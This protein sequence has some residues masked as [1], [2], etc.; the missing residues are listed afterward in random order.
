MPIKLNIALSSGG[1]FKPVSSRTLAETRITIGR[2]DDCTLTL[3]D[4]H[5]HVSRVHAELEEVDGVYMMKVVS[6]VNPVLVNGKRYMFGNRVALAEGD[7]L[8]IG[9]YRLEVAVLERPAKPPVTPDE[10]LTYVA[11][12]LKKPAAPPAPPQV[13]PEE[14]AT[15][16]RRPNAPPV[17]PPAKPPLPEQALDAEEATFVPP[18]KAAPELPK[19][20]PAALSRFAPPGGEEDDGE[21][22]LVRRPAPPA[23]PVVPPTPAAPPD[24]PL[25]AALSRFAP[26]GGE[27]D[28]GEAT[29]MR[30]P[31]TPPAP[32][33]KP[34]PPAMTAEDAEEAT[35]VPQPKAPT[36]VAQATP[37]ASAADEEEATYVPSPSARPPL[38]D[39]ATP[40]ART[41]PPEALDL[42]FDLSEEETFVRPTETAAP[43]PAAAPSA[44]A[45]LSEEATFVRPS[46]PL[47][48]RKPSA[49]FAAAAQEE[50]DSG[51]MTLM[52]RPGSPLPVASPPPSAPAPAAVA[53]A[54][55]TSPASG[56]DALLQA[57]LQGAGLSHLQ[58]PDPERFMRDSGTMVRAAIEGVMMLLIARAEARRDIGAGASEPDGADNPLK[59]MASPA[60]VIT[61][62]FDP[63]RPAIG[64]TDPIQALGEACSDLRIHQVALLA[65]VQAA[66]T[67]ALARVDPHK[68][69]REH[70]TSL[71]GLNLTRKSKLW[72]ISVTQ[73]EQLTREAQ[74]DFNSAFGREILAAYLAQVRKVRR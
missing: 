46:E 42:D 63:K 8:A 32:P 34:A 33:A 14:D 22:T 15:M 40:D 56:G 58:V 10:E 53:P 67:E 73:H 66:V 41:K 38:G 4:A 52:R 45:D 29:L 59:S 68:V 37:P 39:S 64:D 13:P 31:G 65:A 72:D 55:A 5:K 74:E 30:R 20:I 3:E 19:P 17:L 2:D 57:F 28:D 43:A 18:P 47:P 6:K 25:P 61:F 11:P 23:A 21:A 69:E 24:K 49:A 36:P 9:L 35:F 62:L 48:M 71:G 50:D 16:M 44:H 70:G 51:D 7:T 26:P 12:S 27:E 1:R 60:E 54:S